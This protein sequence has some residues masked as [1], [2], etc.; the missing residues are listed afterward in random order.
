MSS[1]K[2]YKCLNCGAGLEFSPTNKLEM[3]LLFSDF[4][5][6]EVE[7]LIMRANCLMKTPRA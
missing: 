6:Q 2:K 5:I 1:V 7:E 3:P 4:S